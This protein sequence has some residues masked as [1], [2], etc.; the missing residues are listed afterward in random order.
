MGVL[1]VYSVHFVLCSSHF[2]RYS[3]A[4]VLAVARVKH[5]QAGLSEKG[6]RWIT[7][8]KILAVGLTSDVVRFRPP[9]T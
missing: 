7:Q 4:N 1:T 3:L 6:I 2:I 8:L 9:T 5:T